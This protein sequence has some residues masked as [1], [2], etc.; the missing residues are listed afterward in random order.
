MVRLLLQ[1]SL[2][3]DLCLLLQIIPQRSHFG[4][5]EWSAHNTVVTRK[6][7]TSPFRP[8][9]EKFRVQL[10]GRFDEGPLLGG[11]SDCR[12]EE[13]RTNPLLYILTTRS[14]VFSNPRKSSVRKRQMHIKCFQASTKCKPAHKQFTHVQ[15]C[16]RT[17]HI[18]RENDKVCVCVCVCVCACVCVC[19]TR[20]SLTSS[21]TS[22]WLTIPLSP[23]DCDVT[24]NQ[25]SPMSLC[26]TK[27][28]PLSKLESKQRNVQSNPGGLCFRFCFCMLLPCFETTHL[29]SSVSGI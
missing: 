27:I 25:P 24:H 7:S 16:V 4:W 26:T 14:F 19:V 22:S 21:C 8:V 12:H 20:W 3:V 2:V 11:W 17:L 10:D 23:V 5:R 29:S 15:T 18:L 9:C 1:R 6:R 28:S 13:I